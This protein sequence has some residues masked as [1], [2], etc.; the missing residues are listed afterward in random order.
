MVT[1]TLVPMRA[2]FGVIVATAEHWPLLSST[3]TV[4]GFLMLS[5]THETLSFSLLLDEHFLG[6]DFDLQLVDAV[7][8][9]GE[10][11]L[12]SGELGP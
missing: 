12:L 11:D 1:C 9:A 6:I 5:S 2:E 8:V 10:I 7:G 3:V 4:L